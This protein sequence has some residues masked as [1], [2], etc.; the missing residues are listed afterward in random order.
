MLFFSVQKFAKQILIDNG[1]INLNI[2]VDDCE[3]QKCE[4]K[5]C[6]EI[7]TLKSNAML[8]VYY[9]Y[10]SSLNNRAAYNEYTCDRDSS[11]DV[12]ALSILRKRELIELFGRSTSVEPI[13]AVI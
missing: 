4:I 7:C 5:F 8:L 13:E 12:F 6:T 1:N 10:D 2:K 9:F 11:A 3:M